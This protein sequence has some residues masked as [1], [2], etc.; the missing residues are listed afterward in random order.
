[1]KRTI[2][3]I[4]CLSLMISCGPNNQDI[5][6]ESYQ[7]K[8]FNESDI[9]EPILLNGMKCDFEELLNPRHIFWEGDFLIVAERGNDTLLHVIDIKSNKHIKRIGVNG[10][11]PGEITM[12]HRMLNDDKPGVFWAYDAEQKRLAKY[13]IYADSPLSEDI[14]DQT[15]DF[16]LAVEMA[17]AS[18]STLMTQRTDKDE[19]FVEFDLR[20]EVVQTFGSWKEMYQVKGVPVS[21]I[22]S[23]HQGQLRSNPKKNKFVKVGVQRDYIEVL[24]R[25]TGNIISIRGP[26]QFMPE[27]KI[28]YSSGYPMPL[29]SIEDPTF[30]TSVSAQSKYFYTL[31]SGKTTHQMIEDQGY[32]R[33]FIF[34]YEGELKQAFELDFPLLSFTVDEENRKFYGITYDAEPNVVVFEF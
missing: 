18:D 16:F 13:D 27:F 23:I 3:R 4:L 31:Y 32:R 1:M 6:S 22:S 11:G 25:D 28:D 5:S 24:D 15:D 21:I 20:G 26:V 17:W 34:D 10:L 33:I 8:T 29:T 12:V 2:I 9:P 19:K 7:I 14:V 30:Y